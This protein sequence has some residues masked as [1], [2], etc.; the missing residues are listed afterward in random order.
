MPNIIALEKMKIYA[1]VLK[2]SLFMKMC[3]FVSNAIIIDVNPVKMDFLVLLVL[4]K[5]KNQ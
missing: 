4:V 3:P 1:S 2:M 5:M